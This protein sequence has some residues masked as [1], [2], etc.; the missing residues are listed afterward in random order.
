MWRQYSEGIVGFESPSSLETKRFQFGAMKKMAVLSCMM[1][2]WSHNHR[3]W[4]S[5]V[6]RKRVNWFEQSTQGWITICRHSGK[7]DLAGNI[8]SLYQKYINT[9]V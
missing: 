6:K 9:G 1:R 2:D 3:L 7:T 5:V 4:V 8:L